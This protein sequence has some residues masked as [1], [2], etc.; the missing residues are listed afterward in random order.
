MVSNNSNGIFEVFEDEESHKIHAIKTNV[1]LA[2][3]NKFNNSNSKVVLI[4]N[5]K[6]KGDLDE[7]VKDANTTDSKE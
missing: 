3:G 2:S 6:R 7:A 5:I 4:K 1:Q